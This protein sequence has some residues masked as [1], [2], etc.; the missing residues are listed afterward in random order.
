MPFALENYW[1][2]DHWIL[3]S[4]NQLDLFYLHAPKS[5]GDPALRHFS[6]RIGH[7]VS[8]DNGD[9][10]EVLPPAILPRETPDFDD[11]AIWTGSAIHLPGGGIRLYYTALSK[12][13]EG[14]AIQRIGWADSTD[15]VTFERKRSWNDPDHLPIEAGTTWYE[16]E[17]SGI[18]DVAWRDPFVFQEEGTWHMIVT[19]SLPHAPEE[20][21]IGTLAHLTSTDMETWEI[22]KPLVEQELFSEL[23]CAQLREID[24]KHWLV[25]SCT[26]RMQQPKTPGFTWIVE[27]P[28]KFG[29]FDIKDA[30][31]LKNTEIYAYQIFQNTDADWKIT[32]FHSSDDATFTGTIPPFI[33]W[34]TDEFTALSDVDLALE[35]N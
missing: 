3:T 7:A 25:F 9:T 14:R 11:R 12:K 35:E 17:Q 10:W 23:E 33:D 30:K 34:G 8:R 16:T 21:Q 20:R 31:Y 27:G 29:P 32:G 2:W 4:D 22:R 15:G 26:P 24:G 19:A 28:T 5:L 18:G 6:A 13:D 1:V